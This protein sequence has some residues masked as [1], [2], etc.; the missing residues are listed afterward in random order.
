VATEISVQGTPRSAVSSG[1]ALGEMS[2]EQ[3]FSPRFA[4][5]SSTSTFLLRAREVL[6]ARKAA[7]AAAD[8]DDIVAVGAICHAASLARKSGLARSTI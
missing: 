1:K 6:G 2:P 7:G 4:L 5:F 8:D 3:I